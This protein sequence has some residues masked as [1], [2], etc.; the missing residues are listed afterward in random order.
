MRFAM[1]RCAL[2]SCLA[3]AATLATAQPRTG[4]WLER[5]M[6]A[7]D[8]PL[9][10]SVD[11]GAAEPWCGLHVDFGD[12]DAR[13]EIVERF[14]LAWTKRYARF[15]RYTVRV[16]GRSVLRGLQS[17]RACAGAPRAVVVTVN[18]LR[19]AA[20]LPAPGGQ[21][22]S[23]REPHDQDERARR[24]DDKRREQ[25]R[26]RQESERDQREAGAR[27]QEDVERVLGLP[28]RGVPPPPAPTRGASP[29]AAPANPETPPRRV[30]D[31]TLDAF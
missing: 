11:F 15:G 22:P 5:P 3:L 8:E 1:A 21:T 31:L 26:R 30:R 6:A 7:V 10:I 20:S 24:E 27:S 12:G 19:P 4:V 9:R 29:P 18:E 2:L 25:D 28:G 13:D 17:A 16:E 23:V 14:P